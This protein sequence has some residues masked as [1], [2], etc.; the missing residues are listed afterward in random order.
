MK[1]FI[2]LFAIF[3]FA[4]SFAP[5]ITFSQEIS[6]VDENVS[7]ENITDSTADRKTLNVTDE[8]FSP[9]EKVS[10]YNVYGMGGGFISAR[11]RIMLGDGSQYAETNSDNLPMLHPVDGYNIALETKLWAALIFKEESM[12]RAGGS[13]LFSYNDG[14]L[15]PIFHIDELYFKWRYPMGD[16]IIGRN[17]CSTFDPMLFGGLLDGIQVNL[18]VPFL[19]FRSFMG[20]TGLLG[21]FHPYNNP[22]SISQYDRTYHEE[23]NIAL[24]EPKYDFLFNAEQAMRFFFCTDF[25]IYL[26]GIHINPYFLMQID[27][28]EMRTDERANDINTLNTFHLGLNNEGRI[29]DT[30]YYKINIIGMFGFSK[31]LQNGEINRLLSC[32]FTSQ[33]RYTFTKAGHSTLMINY[34][35][36]LGNTLFED[37]SADAI[38]YQNE[39]D[40]W[41]DNYHRE[42]NKFYYYGRFDGGYVLNPILSNIHSLSFKYQV[43]P[44]DK[45][46]IKLSLYAGVYQTFKFWTDAD[47]SFKGFKDTNNALVGTEFDIGLNVNCMPVFT[48]GLD[49]GVLIPENGVL[50]MPIFKGGMSF[51]WT[52]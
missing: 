36:G 4:A 29:V 23:S 11:G 28:S 33:L 47:I 17:I 43:T 32:A 21:L 16:I 5:V 41:Y 44:V 7:G 2:L 34:A 13:I 52:I 42:S 1:K 14:K 35:F 20:Y 37:E 8:A 9:K 3:L 40:F 19:N 30:L 46:R 38:V 10:P 24:L 6:S 15:F 22:Y 12:L 18:N 49:F 39:N 45:D 25:D 48:F 27:M 51:V 50:T 26:A 31:D